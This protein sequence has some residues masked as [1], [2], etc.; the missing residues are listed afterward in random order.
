MKITLA[1]NANGNLTVGHDIEGDV[2][3][4]LTWHGLQTEGVAAPGQ[5]CDT[6]V[7]IRSMVLVDDTLA[8][9]TPETI[10]DYETEIAMLRRQL[11]RS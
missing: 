7:R 5:P 10:A 11:E 8:H 3:V 2:P 6:G 4:V 1:I 9:A